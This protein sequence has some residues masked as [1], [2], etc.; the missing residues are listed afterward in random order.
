MRPPVI[1]PDEAMITAGPCT[2][3]DLLRLVDRAGQVHVAV[4]RRRNLDPDEVVH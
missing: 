4:R 3:I 1:M 2:A